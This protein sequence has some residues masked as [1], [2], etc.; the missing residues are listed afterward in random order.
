[1]ENIM[2]VKIKGS[3]ND[4]FP[5]IKNND[6]LFYEEIPKIFVSF[7]SAYNVLSGEKEKIDIIEKQP[8]K[9]KE[10][11]RKELFHFGHK[12]SNE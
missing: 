10:I 7:L 11:L 6:N 1:M 9:L 3:F 12:F 8:D 5:V 4:D 2:I